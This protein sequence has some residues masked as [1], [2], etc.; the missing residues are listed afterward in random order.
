MVRDGVL[1][2]M[3]H[4]Q[5]KRMK[6]AVLFNKRGRRGEMEIATQRESRQGER[7]KC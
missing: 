6:R 5:V 7:K 1:Y 4:S 2:A 3:L